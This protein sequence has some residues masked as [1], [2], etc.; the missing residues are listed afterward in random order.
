MIIDKEFRDWVGIAKYLKISTAKNALL[1]L[2]IN[3]TAGLFLAI[4][5]EVSIYYAP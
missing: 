4:R 3:V 2:T 1:Y 5:N